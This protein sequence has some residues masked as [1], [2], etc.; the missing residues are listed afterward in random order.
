MGV[1][2]VNV[3]MHACSATRPLIRPVSSLYSMS[4]FHWRKGFRNF[5]YSLRYM[6]MVKFILK[7]ELKYEAMSIPLMPVYDIAAWFGVM[8]TYWIK[9][10]SP[11][12]SK[13]ILFFSSSFVNSKFLAAVLLPSDHGGS[14]LQQTNMYRSKIIC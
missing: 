8:N 1:T 3:M 6:H 2:L 14:K 7:L 12:E 4:W 9:S 10:I 5:E 13:L 11:F